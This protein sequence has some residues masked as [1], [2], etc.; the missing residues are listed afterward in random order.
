MAT[1]TCIFRFKPRTSLASGTSVGNS[2][3]RLTI[4]RVSTSAKKGR[5]FTVNL[6]Y[7][8]GYGKK[9]DRSIDISGPSDAKT[10]VLHGE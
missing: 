8:F 5:A 3:P 7:T 9:V 2:L 1:E 10:S 6:T 4:R